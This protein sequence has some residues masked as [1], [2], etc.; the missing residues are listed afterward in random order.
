[1]ATIDTTMTFRCARCSRVVAV[2]VADA[3]YMLPTTSASS[4]AVEYLCE[5]CWREIGGG[6]DG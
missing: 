1:M 4:L 2:A 6:D 5:D 3:M